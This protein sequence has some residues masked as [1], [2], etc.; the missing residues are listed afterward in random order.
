MSRRTGWLIAGV[1]LIGSVALAALMVSRRPE[2]ERRPQPSQVPFAITAPVAA[3]DGAIPVYGAGTVRPRAEIDIAAEV[4]G[5]VVWVN[6]ALQSGGRVREGQALLRIDGADY[7]S[8]VEQRRA[9]VALQRVELLK[10]KEEAQVART[11]YEQFKQRRADEGSASDASPL[12]LWQPQ[13]EAAEAVLARDSAALAEAELNLSRTEVKAPFSGVVRTESVDVGQFVAAGQGV[14]RLYASDAVEVVVPLS[15]T[16]AALLPG[17]WDLR[18]GDANR[19]IAARV[20][21]EYGDG[22]YTWEGY[23]DR[24]EA[25]LDEQTR[26]IEVIVRV[27]RPFSAGAAEKAGDEDPVA[28]AGGGPPLLVGKFVEVEL[29][30]VAPEKYFI[31][32]RSAFRPGSE[33]WA[34]RDDTVTI[35][36]IRVLQRLDDNVFVIGELQPREAVVVGGIQVATEGM[37]VRT[38]AAG[39]Q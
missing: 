3:G 9:D 22:R 26:T 5:K 15:D 36:P 4:S 16:G 24:A 6:P 17:L 19:R 37:A 10:V 32:R 21:A 23:V 2:P 29:Q 38:E 35:V 34:V 11:Q 39:S 33:V 31:V 8:Q 20:T 12:A 14:G 13:L 27:P 18:A 28:E 1:I 25:F 7:R 30:G